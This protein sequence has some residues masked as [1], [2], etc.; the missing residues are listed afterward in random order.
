MNSQIPCKPYVMIN[1]TKTN[2]WNTP[3][4]H[5]QPN[6]VT[7][8][9]YI[10]DKLKCISIKYKLRNYFEEHFIST[11]ATIFKNT[12]LIQYCIVLAEKYRKEEDVRIITHLKHISEIHINTGS[13]SYRSIEEM[14]LICNNLNL[15][16]DLLCFFTINTYTHN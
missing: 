3:P 10:N 11:Y 7:H 8:D 4:L 13:Y 16:E 1:E 2:D 6:S 12:L 5:N 9:T 15:L 14:L